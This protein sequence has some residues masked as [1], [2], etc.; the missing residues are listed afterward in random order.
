MKEPF[1]YDTVR[2]GEDTVLVID[3]EAYSR[4]PSI[5]DDS[6]TMARTIDILTQEPSVTK[7]VYEQKRK[8]EY[9]YEQTEM[10]KELARL[11]LHLVKAHDL[12]SYEALPPE[13]RL[14]IPNWY[15]QLKSLLGTTLKSD[16]I[17][18]FVELR[19]L[20]RQEALNLERSAEPEYTHVMKA[21]ISL[22]KKLIELLGQLTLVKR[23]K[24]SGHTPGTRE[25]YQQ[26][27]RPLIKPDFMFT[28]LMASYPPEG[29][30]LDNYSLPNGSEVTIFEIPGTVQYL[31]HLTPPEFRLDEDEYEILDTAR[32][33]LAE[34]KPRRQDFIDPERIRQVFSNVGRD[35]VEELAQN[36]NIRLKEAQVTLLTDILVRYTIGFGLIEVLL[37]DEKIQDITI[38]SPM[39]E[40][41]MFLVHQDF[42]DCMTNII[43]TQPESESWASKL[44]LVSGRPLDEANPI[45]DTE[46]V[47]PGA[48]TRVAVISSPLNPSGLAYAFRRHRDKP[49]TLALLIQK[50]ML[51][52]L[53]AGIISFLIDGSRTLLI[54]GTRSAGKTSL[55]SAVMVEVMRRSRMITIE[56]TLELPVSQLRKL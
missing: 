15:A 35:L 48:N 8:Y 17:G 32:K 31:Y 44:R 24:A 21:Y 9:D 10:L 38:N 3:C 26:F 4:V 25:I 1:S 23:A 14:Y 16:P 50:R 12:L 45:L 22:L 37:S 30:E 28:R 36:K 41:P 27:F 39:G 49:W 54:A 19:R 11:C 53:S 20:E 33:I 52:P 42:G 2:E 29:T 56:D 55:L 51:D 7:I 46:L 43:P 47:L 5:E 6:L 34:H 13:A 18:A 40:A